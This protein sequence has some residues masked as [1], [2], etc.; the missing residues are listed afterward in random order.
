MPHYTGSCYCHK[1]QYEIDL[2]SPD[3]ARTSLCHCSNCKKFTGGP[4]GITT[5]IKKNSFRITQG[6]LKE[7]LS[8]NGSGS[9]LHRKFCDECGTGILEYG[10]HAGDSIYIFHG[11]LDDPNALPPKGEFFTK[12]KEP[13]LPEFTSLDFHKKEIHD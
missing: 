2:S 1:V 5:K 4:F 8:D 13:W 12:V 3:D 10:E 9:Q 11:T 7:H 6:D